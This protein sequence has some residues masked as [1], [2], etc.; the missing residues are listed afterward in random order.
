MVSQCSSVVVASG[1]GITM[2]FV[3]WVAVLQSESCDACLEFEE[4][5][6]PSWS[7]LAPAFKQKGRLRKVNPAVYITYYQSGSLYGL[8]RQQ[9]L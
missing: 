1:H 8:R 2:L 9:P 3:A 4:H 6:R 5:G 7:F